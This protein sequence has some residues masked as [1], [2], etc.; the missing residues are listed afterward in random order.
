MGYQDE[1]ERER[2]RER[3]FH[4]NVVRL[5]MLYDTKCWAIEKHAHKIIV[6][7]MKMLR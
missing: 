1:R 2:E 6:V 7:E 3:E 4:K 5:T